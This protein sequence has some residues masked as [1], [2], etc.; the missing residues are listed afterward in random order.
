MTAPIFILAGEPSGDRL[1]SHI[2]QAV[3]KRYDNPGWIGVGGELMHKE[4]L[5]SL[6]DMETLSVMGFGSALA[7]YHRLSALADIL[8]E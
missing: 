2:M 1:A 4:G 5:D 6:I 7:S 3:N 8:V